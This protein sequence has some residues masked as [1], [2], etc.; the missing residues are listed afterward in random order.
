MDMVIDDVNIVAHIV[1]FLHS[2][3]DQL[4]ASLVCKLWSKAVILIIQKVSVR[5]HRLVCRLLQ[6]FSNLRVLDFSYC[7]DLV[8]DS[9]IINAVPY[10]AGLEQVLLGHPDNVQNRLS[11]N[12]VIS[13]A[14]H[15]PRLKHISLSSLSNISNKSIISLA[16]HCRALCS[17]VLEDCFYLDDSAVLAISRC[18]N[19]QEL[20][21]KGEFGFT[22]QGLAVI[23]QKCTALRCVNFEL[24]KIDV[25]LALGSI[26]TGCPCLLECSLKVKS[27]D[28]VELAKCTTLACFRLETSQWNSLDQTIIA[29]ANA[30][31]NLK[32]L[33]FL[34]EYVPLSDTAIISIIQSCQGLEKLYVSAGKLTEVSL[35]FLMECKSLKHLNLDHFNSSQQGLAELWLYGLD[36]KSFSLKSGQNFRDVELQMLVQCSRKLEQLDLWGCRGLSSIGFSAIC[37]LKNLQSL[38]LSFTQVDNLSL[39]YI[40]HGINGLKYL[41]LAKCLSISDMTI[42]AQ[43]SCL[44]YLNLDQCAFV[45][46]E[47]LLNIGISCSQLAYV[48]LAFT[49]I[50]DKGLLSLTHCSQLQSLSIPYCRSVEGSALVSL[51]EACPGFRF[52]VLSHRFRNSKLLEKLKNKYCMVRLEADELALV[53][54]GFNLLI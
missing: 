12:A 11:D 1:S 43:F 31:K 23:G 26:S 20:T 27:V 41:S 7:C 47:G 24:C 50:T 4:S 5:S 48:S 37:Q 52:V 22:S 30:N 54:L 2:P 40:A 42:I 18:S 46:D 6:R 16:R 44:K 35:H 51:A 25:G 15:C 21:F 34:N 36:L 3:R 53:P 39:M 14:V 19:L 29:I 9:D 13:L 45:H 8:E 33:T 17:V 10:F 49:Q 32:E 38:D 28:P